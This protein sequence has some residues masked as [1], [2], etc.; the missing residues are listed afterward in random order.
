MYLSQLAQALVDSINT[1]PP[2]NW[3]GSTGS[4]LV[5]P[6]HLEAKFA[7]DPWTQSTASE[8]D[9]F[10]IPGFIEYDFTTRRKPPAPPSR[11]KYVTVAISARIGAT[12][13]TPTY[14][15]TTEAEGIQL[16]DIKEDLDEYVLKTVL[17]VGSEKAYVTSMDVEPANELQFKDSF[18]V[19]ISI[20]EYVSC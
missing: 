15:I 1:S 9:I 20:V 2:E 11:K 18:Y 5:V 17:T 14:D 8:L 16:T 19:T 3:G 13:D 7:L 4:G 12:T 10:V 6:T